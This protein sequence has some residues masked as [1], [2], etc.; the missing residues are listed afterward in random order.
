MITKFIKFIELNFS[1]IT[2]CFDIKV[3][4]LEGPVVRL[5]INPMIQ[6]EPEDL[7]KD[8]PKLEIAVL[9]QYLVDISENIRSDTDEVFTMKMEILLESAS[10]KLLVGLQNSHD[11]RASYLGFYVDGSALW[12][13]RKIAFKGYLNG[14]SWATD[15]MRLRYDLSAYKKVI[16]VEDQSYEDD[17]DSGGP[18]RFFTVRSAS[19]LNN[20]ELYLDQ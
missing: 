16:K 14:L 2:R 13:G 1:V 8:N 6:P 18:T 11:A 4:M 12:Q 7:P 9:R 5:G 10:N 3:G 20:S 15:N 19:P 17:L